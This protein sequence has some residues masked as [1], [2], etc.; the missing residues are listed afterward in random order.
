MENSRVAVRPQSQ[1]CV[2][3]RSLAKDQLCRQTR[4]W[5]KRIQ[6]RKARGDGEEGRQGQ[7]K[8][9]DKQSNRRKEIRQQRNNNLE[10]ISPKKLLDLFHY[11]RSKPHR[12]KGMRELTIMEEAA[13]H[14]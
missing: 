5:I 12:C 1:L 7:K 10:S 13:S 6:T 2:Q 9:A 8:R 11:H 3:G 4:D 14:L